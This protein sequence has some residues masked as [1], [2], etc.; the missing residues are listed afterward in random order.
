[1]VGLTVTI[2]GAYILVQKKKVVRDAIDFFLDPS[3]IMC[4]AGSIT[5][6][7]TFFGCMGALRENTCF[8]RFVSLTCSK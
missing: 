3:T 1:V 2:L 8:L 4:T 7:V 5:V 6:F